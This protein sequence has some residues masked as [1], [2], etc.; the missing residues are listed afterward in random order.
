[1]GKHKT[2][3]AV[4]ERRA[5]AVQQIFAWRVDE[6]LGYR[7]IA[8]RLNDDLDRYPPPQP[9]DPERAVG[10]WTGSSVREVLINPKYPGHMCWNRR[11]TKD[12]IH[13]GKNNPRTEWV[14]ST[15]PT[16]PAIISVE[17]FLAAQN[18]RRAGQGSRTISTPQG[19]N[20]HRCTKRI[21]RLRSYVRCGICTRRMHGKTKRERPHYCCQPRPAIDGHPPTVWITERPLL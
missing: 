3:L 2:K 12:K 5:P 11:S 17:T 20:P 15:E 1:E 6:R 19:A 16:H 7:A 9:V 13:P 14:L 10:R 4:D 21:Y 8:E 18:L